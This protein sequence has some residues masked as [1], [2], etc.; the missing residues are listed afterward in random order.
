MYEIKRTGYGYLLVFEGGLTAEEV[1]AWRDACA[2][3]VRTASGPFGTLV[4]AR[5]LPAFPKQILQGIVEGQKIMLKAGLERSAVILRD[6]DTAE[7]FQTAARKSGLAER[8]RILHATRVF[9]W[10]VA[11]VRWIEEGIEP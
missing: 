1:R 9:N 8:E 6:F 2:S 4:D 5:T 11:A 7:L 3:A 10:D